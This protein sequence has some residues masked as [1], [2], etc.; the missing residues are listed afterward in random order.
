[1]A[2]WYGGQF[3]LDVHEVTPFVPLEC[4]GSDAKHRSITTRRLDMFV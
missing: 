2:V 1:M 4:I 3:E